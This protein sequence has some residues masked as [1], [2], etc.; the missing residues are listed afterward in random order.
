MTPNYRSNDPPTSALAG[1]TI[2]ASGTA[3]QQRRQCL[4]AVAA[5]PGLTAREIEAHIGIKAH[6]RLPELRAAGLI[7]NGPARTCSV[8]GRLALTWDPDGYRFAVGH[9]A[10]PRNIQSTPYT[11]ACA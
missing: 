10:H 9:H 6:K 1:Q 7:R 2:E 3:R 8:S 5:M 4:E 11:G